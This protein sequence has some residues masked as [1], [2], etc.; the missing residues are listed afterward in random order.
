VIVGDGAPDLH[1]FS[2]PVLHARLRATA[3]PQV[4]GKVVAFAGIGRPEKF[5]ASL[6]AFGAEIIDARAYPDHRA[7]TASEIARLKA[8]A[9]NANA[10]LI[11]TEKDYVRLT[12]AEREGIAFLPVHAAFD[13]TAALGRLLDT[14]GLAV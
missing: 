10:A 1:K 3:I 7:Y 11:T 9:R 5:F 8:R 14:L 6:R 4:N 13:D 2:G 12:D